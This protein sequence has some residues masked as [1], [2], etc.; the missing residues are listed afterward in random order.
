MVL[1]DNQGISP[2]IVLD[3]KAFEDAS[4]NSDFDIDLYLNDEEDNGDNM[5]V[6]QTPKEEVRTRIYNTRI[7]PSLVRGIMEDKI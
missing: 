2:K 1:P 7:P 4:N 3:D 5:V 6:P